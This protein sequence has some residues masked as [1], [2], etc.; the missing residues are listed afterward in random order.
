MVLS[1]DKANIKK[2]WQ[3]IARIKENDEVIQGKVVSTVKG[4]LNVDI[5][6]QG[7]FARQP[8]GYSTLLEN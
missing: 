4:G 6:G 5:G 3:D 1:K 8:D 7:F 2:V